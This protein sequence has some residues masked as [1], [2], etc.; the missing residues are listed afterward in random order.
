MRQNLFQRIMS[1]LRHSVKDYFLY[2]SLGKSI[3]AQKIETNMVLDFLNEMRMQCGS[4]GTSRV[5]NSVVD[6]NFIVVKESKDL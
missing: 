1:F 6:I 4:S 2:S 5:Q 3:L